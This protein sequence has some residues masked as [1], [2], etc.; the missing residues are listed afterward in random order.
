V[1]GGWT[2]TDPPVVRWWSVVW[3]VGLGVVAVA[4]VVGTGVGIGVVVAAVVVVAGVTVGCV[5]TVGAV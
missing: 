4:V 3:G 5:I 2:D 1:R